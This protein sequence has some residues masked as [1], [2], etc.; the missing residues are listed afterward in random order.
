MVLAAPFVVARMAKD[1]TRA[2]YVATGRGGVEISGAGRG[3]KY[4]N[5]LVSIFTF[6]SVSGDD[7]ASKL[8]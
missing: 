3:Y 7:E 1:S 8:G 6:H 5:C 2:G 4:E